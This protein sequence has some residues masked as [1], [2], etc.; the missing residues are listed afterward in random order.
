MLCQIRKKKKTV[1]RVYLLLVV[2]F[3]WGQSLLPGNQS[4]KESGFILEKIVHPIEKALTGKET[5]TEYQ[6]RK[7]A[8]VLEFAALGFG[9]CL[10][11]ICLWEQKI[12]GSKW[13]WA[14]R[15]VGTGMLIAFLD[16]TIQL[17]TGRGSQIRDVWIDT[18]GVFLGTLAALIV[19]ALFSRHKQERLIK[20]EGIQ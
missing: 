5:I 7:A 20:R 3:I 11:F 19:T 16:E 17:F 15:G 1:L 18:G 10:Y 12:P 4:S 6:V 13:L 14:L 8:H 2:S 9:L